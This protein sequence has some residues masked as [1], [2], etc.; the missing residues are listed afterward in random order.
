MTLKLT[1]NKSLILSIFFTNP[2]KSF[3]L[4]ELARMLGIE[5]GVFQKDIN[6]LEKDGLLK[7]TF[8]GRS[9]FFALNK[10]YPLYQEIRNIIKK[11]VGIEKLLENKLKKIKGIKKAFIHGSFAKGDADTFSDVDLIIVGNPDQFKLNSELKSL[12]EQFDREIN[13]TLYSLKEFERKKRSPFLETVLKE[14]KIIL[15]N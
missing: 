4:R 8:R 11:T 14:K 5:P 13:Y 9:R 10:D 7:S 15:I 12:E 6:N 3:Y 1:K 2:E